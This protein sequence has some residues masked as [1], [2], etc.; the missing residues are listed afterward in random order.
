MICSIKMY[1]FSCWSYR[2]MH[3]QIETTASFF[4]FEKVGHSHRITVLTKA[5]LKMNLHNDSFGANAFYQ[6][7]NYSCVLG[8]NREKKYES[9]MGVMGEKK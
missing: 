1:A 9:R 8:Q 7:K 3:F 5:P 2:K 6:V 4:F